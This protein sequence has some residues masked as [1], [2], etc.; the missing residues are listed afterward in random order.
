MNRLSYE[1]DDRFMNN[2]I[3]NM[4][5]KKTDNPLKYDIHPLDFIKKKV[6]DDIYNTINIAENGLSSW[7]KNRRASLDES[8][9]ELFSP[10][11]EY[12][13]FHNDF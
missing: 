11:Q 13:E 8:D 12:D 1:N 10:Q 3:T 6:S 9:G 4:L 5:E 2:Q 7:E